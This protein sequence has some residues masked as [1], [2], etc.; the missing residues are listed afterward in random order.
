MAQVVSNTLRS[1]KESPTNE[2]VEMLVSIGVDSN[3]SK[4][5]VALSDGEFRSSS[6]LQRICKLR[7]PEISMAMQYLLSTEM[8]SYEPQKSG[9]RGRPIHRYSLNGEFAEIIQP[10]ILEAEEHINQL[11][12]DLARL[13]AVSNDLAAAMSDDL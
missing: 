7:Q 2:M 13:D 3:V 11:A 1:N 9:G 6:N 4:V 12:S 10:F 8:V 5:L